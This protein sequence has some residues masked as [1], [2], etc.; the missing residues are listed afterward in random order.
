MTQPIYLED[1]TYLLQPT[2]PTKNLIFDLNEEQ[3]AVSVTNNTENDGA[4]FSISI[5]HNALTLHTLNSG[6]VYNAPNP[7]AG[8]HFHI[9]NTGN[10]V[11]EVDIA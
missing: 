9:L 6:G 4:Q 2:Q 3:D 5:N 7:T 1:G 8:M 11:L 10:I